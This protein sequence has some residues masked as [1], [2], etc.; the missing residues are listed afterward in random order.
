MQPRRP[1]R[2]GLLR[3][4]RAE[5]PE[6]RAAS[7][8]ARVTHLEAMIEGLQDAVHR[9]TMRTHSEL[10]EVRRLLEPSELSRAISKDARERGL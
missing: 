3:F 6:D 5:L 9:E 7:L 4:R 8:E 2:P 10:D 1:K